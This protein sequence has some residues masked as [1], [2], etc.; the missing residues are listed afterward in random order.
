[1][2]PLMLC[3]TVCVFGLGLIG[4]L[5]VQLAHLSGCFVIGIDLDVTRLD[6]AKKYGADVFCTPI[7]HLRRVPYE[8]YCRAGER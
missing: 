8:T 1:M 6:L 7:S 3:E 5:T 4:Q 2:A